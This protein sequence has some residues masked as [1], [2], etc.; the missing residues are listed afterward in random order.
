[1]SVKLWSIIRVG[2]SR[3][4]ACA[5]TH[6]HFDT[7]L[8]LSCVMPNFVPK[9]LIYILNCS[10]RFWWFP[11]TLII[12]TFS[13]P[14]QPVCSVC[15]NDRLRAKHCLTNRLDRVKFLYILASGNFGLWNFISKYSEILST[16][17]RTGMPEFEFSTFFE[18]LKKWIFLLSVALLSIIVTNHY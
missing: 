11:P 13:W 4:A 8:S 5:A 17:L 15:S 12:M 16:F 18:F 14:F 1:M 9:K 3:Y 2:G 7:F 10:P 6:P